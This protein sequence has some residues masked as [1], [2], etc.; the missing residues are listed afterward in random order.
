[1]HVVAEFA[2][3]S[4]PAYT[5]NPSPAQ[6]GQLY[7]SAKLLFLEG[8]LGEGGL[9]KMNEHLLPVDSEGWRMRKAASM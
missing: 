1:M 3:L 8:I 5:A 9:I 2:K 6:Q 4:P 7:M